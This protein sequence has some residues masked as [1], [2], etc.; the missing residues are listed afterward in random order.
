MID[1]IRIYK[2][3]HLN[4]DATMVRPKKFNKAQREMSFELLDKGYSYNQ[5]TEMT[6]IS[7]RTLIRYNNEC[8]IKE[9]EDSN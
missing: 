4:A 6:C 2:K 3:I 8:K 7:R 5:V 1:K 9:I